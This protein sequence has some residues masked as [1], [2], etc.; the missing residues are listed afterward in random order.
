MNEGIRCADQCC[1]IRGIL[2]EV[3]GDEPG[4]HADK[5]SAT[6]LIPAKPDH[7]MTTIQQHPADAQAQKSGGSRD[8][9]PHGAFR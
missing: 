4:A 6:L 8:D 5:L 3:V 1:N 7:F 2:R 9:N